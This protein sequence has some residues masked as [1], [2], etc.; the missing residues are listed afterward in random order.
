MTAL[1]WAIGF[2]ICLGIPCA[3]IALAACRATGG[4]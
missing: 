3:V 4:E 2:L 1:G